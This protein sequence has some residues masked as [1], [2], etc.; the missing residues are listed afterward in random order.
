MVNRYDNNKIEISA[1]INRLKKSEK[2]M[3]AVNSGVPPLATE[4][5]H[6]VKLFK[7]IKTKLTKSTKAMNF[8]N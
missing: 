1:K 2:K 6:P 5:V 7:A 4:H 8:L 3:L